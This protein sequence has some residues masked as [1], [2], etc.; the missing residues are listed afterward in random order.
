MLAGVCIGL[1]LVCCSLLSAQVSF[2]ADEYDW[3]YF[4]F[5]TY[6]VDC[7]SV[8][9]APCAIDV[10]VLSDSCLVIAN[11]RQH[12]FSFYKGEY[13]TAERIIIKGSDEQDFI[14]VHG[15]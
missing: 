13:E 11:G 9:N 1:S 6:T 12:L 5:I 3:G 8:Q 4:N 14:N 2:S 10:Y 15:D 7:R